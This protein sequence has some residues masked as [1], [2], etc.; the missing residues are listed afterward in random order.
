ME[1]V[2]AGAG[3]AP[4]QGAPPGHGVHA[5]SVQA[6][7]LAGGAGRRFG[8]DKTA[9]TV[10]GTSLLG[11]AVRAAAAAGAVGVVVV[12]PRLPEDVQ[13]SCPVVLTREDPPGSGPVAGLRAGLAVVDADVVLLLAA[14]LPHVPQ[15]ALRAMVSGLVADAGADA[16]VAEDGGGRAQWLTAAYR[17]APLR[18]A[19]ED[20][21][22]DAGAGAGAAARAGAGDGAGDRATGARPPGLKHVVARLRWTGAPRG[23]GGAGWW[24]WTPPRT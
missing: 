22:G 6:V 21:V 3:G 23:P 15:E 12:G 4:R 9:A 11:H 24:T 8:G 10:G 1:P 16:V 19:V 17:T 18:A 5:P 2:V 14:D 20:V 13:V 7:V